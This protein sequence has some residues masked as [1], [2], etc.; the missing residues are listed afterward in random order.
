M[1]ALR[2]LE[3][4]KTWTLSSSAGEVVVER[5][6]GIIRSLA[7][8]R[9]R[10][11]V[12]LM[13]Q[14]RQNQ[15]GY[16]GGLRIYDEL[17]RKWYDDWSGRPRVVRGRLSGDTL[18]VLKRY[19][20]APFTVE[21]R[22]ELKGAQLAWEV[23]CRQQQ[24]VNRQ[25]RVHLQ[26]PIIAG[27][28]C[29]T[30]A[31]TQGD[32]IY[33][34]PNVP[35][36]FD[37]MTSFDYYY[38]QGPYV[39]NNDIVVP[40][41]CMYDPQQDVGISFGE[42]LDRNVPASVFRFSNGQRCFNWGL[43]EKP[44]LEDYPYFEVVHS[45]IG[46]RGTKPCS[47]GGLIFLHEGDWR[48]GLGLYYKRF[49][50]WFAPACEK[51]Y[52]REGVFECGNVFM[53]D[54][55]E[56]YKDLGG[57]YL[58]VHSH[59]PWYGCYF[60]E[61][62]QEWYTI[63]HLEREYI[64]A[65]R[66]PRQFRKLSQELIYAKLKALKE[67]G[68]S[69]HYYFNY[70]DGY[71]D[72]VEE[73]FGDSIVK[74]ENGE[75][76]PSGWRL[77]HCMNPDP[78]ASFGKYM[79]A[80][81]KKV[82]A[83]YGEVLD[84]FFLDCFRH[85]EFDFGRDDGVAMVNNK[86]VSSVNHMLSCVQALVGRL[87]RRRGMDCFANKPRTMAVMRDVDAVLLEGSG[88]ASEVKF[89]YCCIGMPLFYMWTSNI[90]DQEEFLK[91]S[92]IL[93]GWP[94]D[95]VLS[96]TDEDQKRRE[97]EKYK[98]LY[99]KYL[100]LYRHFSRRVLCFEPDPVTFSDGIYGQVYTRPDGAYVVGVMADWLGVDDQVRRQKAPRVQLR[101]KNADRIGGVQV[102]YAG[103]AE[104]MDVAPKAAGAELVVDLPELVSAAV[105][106]C[107]PG[108]GGLARGGATKVERKVEGLGDPTVAYELGTGAKEG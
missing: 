95:P 6:T 88:D 98:E 33:Q 41:F 12:D 50:R 104:P 14:L 91:R 105:V 37:G 89:Y 100:P 1:K 17:D 66:R 56:D 62:K 97:L 65:G 13:G 9:G 81:A 64:P 47:T 75:L 32:D 72:W 83:R 80:T 99:R 73:H 101:L 86:P 7:V 28:S 68:I 27:W 29:F 93:G 70:T 79:V 53:A 21:L 10:K 18:T 85:F 8:K 52:E 102:H 46:M 78:Q 42:H 76:A 84:G 58:E 15:V 71:R 26:L 19:P 55:M 38:N 90:K 30:T 23:T 61:D 69:S 39:G 92:V 24:K 43:Q 51:V 108:E 82:L 57:K 49:K 45:H 94:R 96:G 44:N 20:G 16:M 77:C 25:I 107:L 36:R 106:L 3:K 87:L 34:G 54:R 11:L 67:G 59:F 103:Q 60:P 63:D 4:I 48:P 2:P 31:N 35:W 40:F 74:A 22:L 5:S